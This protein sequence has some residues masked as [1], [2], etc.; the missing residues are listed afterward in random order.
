MNI[1][2]VYADREFH[3]ADAILALEERD[4]KYVI[5]AKKDRHR[6]GPLCDQ[7]DRLKSGY[8]EPNDTPLYVKRDHTIYGAVKGGVTNERV[9]TTVVMLPPDEDDDT[10]PAGSPQP[11]LTNL[12]VSDEISLDQRWAAEQIEE[13][14]D[15]GAIENSYSS[16]KKA[17]AWTTSKE[18]EVRWFHFAFGCL[19][20]NMWLLVD[21][22]TQERTG[23][24]KTRKK[25]RIS[26]SRFLSWLDKELVALL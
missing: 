11:F 19:V 4:L 1:R 12:E 18:F 24:I 16:I 10:N 13:Y 22:L 3:A 6:I 26:L 23:V 7:F 15:C 14:S 8:D 9:Y 2:R 5:P 17:A 25:P 21:F 20:Y